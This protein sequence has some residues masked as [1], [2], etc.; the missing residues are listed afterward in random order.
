MN[1]NDLTSSEK[2]KIKDYVKKN[3]PKNDIDFDKINVERI[4]DDCLKIKYNGI[5]VEVP[6]SKPDQNTTNAIWLT[7]AGGVIAIAAFAT[8]MKFKE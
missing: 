1:F 7:L 6:I 3:N 2:E 4:S 5:T 8:A